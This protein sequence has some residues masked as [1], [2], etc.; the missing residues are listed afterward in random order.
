MPLGTWC[1]AGAHGRKFTQSCR[2]TNASGVHGPTESVVRTSWHDFARP[3]IAPVNQGKVS[4]KK[5]L[6]Q[7]RALC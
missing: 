1:V 3:D 5:T 7:V 4:Q 6:P 2:P